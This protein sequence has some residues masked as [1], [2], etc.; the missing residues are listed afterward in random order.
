MA[1]TS[2]EMLCLIG[3]ACLWLPLLAEVCTVSC[4][5]LMRM[6]F[7]FIVQCALIYYFLLCVSLC[8]LSFFFEA[9][10]RDGHALL[11]SAAFH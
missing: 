11:T 1:L 2:R 8:V 5:L 6:Y 3:T 10:S 4:L 7:F 9:M